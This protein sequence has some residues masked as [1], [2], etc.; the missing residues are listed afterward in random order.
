MRYG[1][2]MLYDHTNMQMKT[3]NFLVKWRILRSHA[4]E[5][6]HGDRTGV[7]KYTYGQI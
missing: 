1:N 3:T 2:Q 5:L 7:F 4:F 6:S